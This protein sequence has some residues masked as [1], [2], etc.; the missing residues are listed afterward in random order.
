MKRTAVLAIALFAVGLVVMRA[1]DEARE[2]E[3]HA[4]SHPVELPVAPPVRDWPRLPVD[5][6]HEAHATVLALADGPRA[7]GES[8][9]D[10]RT[11]M[12]AVEHYRLFV[13]LAELT[14][15]QEQVFLQVVADLGVQY[16]YLERE[17]VYAGPDEGGQMLND[18]GLVARDEVRVA[19]E[20]VLSPEQMRLFD[21]VFNVSGAFLSLPRAVTIASI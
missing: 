16:P 21:V 6:V 8:D 10:F 4:A 19:M 3:E 17:V 5:E 11:R 2:R 1:N 13:E 12:S 18:Y 9:M 7:A 14:E 20:P 15:A